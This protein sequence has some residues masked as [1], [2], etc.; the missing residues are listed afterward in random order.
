MGG[1][2]RLD[3]S[4]TPSLPH[5]VDSLRQCKD[6]PKGS[7]RAV[8]EKS[9]EMRNPLKSTE[10][11]VCYR[12]TPLTSRDS[13]TAEHRFRKEVSPLQTPSPPTTSLTLNGLSLLVPITSSHFPSIPRK[14]DTIWTPKSRPSGE[15]LVPG[16]SR[17]TIED[18]ISGRPSAPLVHTP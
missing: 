17:S 8:K 4:P 11:T 6:N 18:V 9:P 3:R 5:R 14:L 10:A 7:N 2:S 13:S 12:F 15:P 16:D 1:V